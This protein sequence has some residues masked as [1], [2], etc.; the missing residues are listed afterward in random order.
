MEIISPIMKKIIIYTDG[1][2]LGNPGPGGYAAIITSGE[3]RKEFSGGFRLTTNNRM[4]LMA[5]IKGLEALKYR[6]EVQ[7][8]SDSKYIVDGISK[9]WAEKWKINNW[10]RSNKG[11]AENIDLWERLL[12]LNQTHV[13]N[14]VWVKGHDGHPE[15]E[16]CDQIAKQ[17]ASGPLLE[18]D[19]GYKYNN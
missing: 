5:C 8:F 17:A 1:C 13:I 19:I 6:C 9:G 3:H 10:K 14:F 16:R 2:C 11:K 15:N 12:Q 4:E 7:I 18:E